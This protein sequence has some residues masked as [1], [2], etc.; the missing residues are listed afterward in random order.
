MTKG[1]NK[2]IQTSTKTEKLLDITSTITSAIPWLG[3]PISNVL[4]GISVER[5]L[6]RVKEVL[7]LLADDLQD[8]KSEVSESYVST[9]E[10][11]EL[12][13]ET[14]KRVGNERNE[15]KRLLYKR[16]LSNSIKTPGMEYDKQLHLL[17]TFEQLSLGHIQLLKALTQKPSGRTKRISSPMSTLSERLPNY[18]E[19]FI[20][21]QVN[22]LN[23]LGI[24]NLNNLNL[25]MTGEG[26]SNLAHVITKLG[27]Q[28]I[29]FI[30]ED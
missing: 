18:D 22:Q 3:G 2:Q 27:Q 15:E 29:E 19:E 21:E 9:D 28:I 16:F 5:K 13:E 8:F 26:A 24:T 10:F 17:N 4:S 11:Q 23:R 14:L 6:K 25:N 30:N 20:K 12:L 1:E 7:E